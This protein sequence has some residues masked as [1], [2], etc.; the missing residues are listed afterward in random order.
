MKCFGLRVWDRVTYRQADI[1]RK[2]FEAVV[3]DP[4]A[5]SA[6]CRAGLL[7]LSP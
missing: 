5:S 3:S 7:S 4:A 1:R 6:S 2:G